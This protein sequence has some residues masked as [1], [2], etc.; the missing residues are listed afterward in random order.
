[1]LELNCQTGWKPLANWFGVFTV[2][3][4]F[5]G[6]SAGHFLTDGV[7]L[8]LLSLLLFP[9]FWGVGVLAPHSH[10]LDST[11]LVNY[12]SVRPPPPPSSPFSGLPLF[13]GFGRFWA[14]HE[15]S[16]IFLWNLAI[17]APDVNLVGRGC[18]GGDISSPASAS[19]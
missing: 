14:V 17:P 4:Q 7:I 10:T 13:P 5:W 19:S 12:V 18:S 9:G 8:L 2:F 15:F 6:P 1:M 11:I 3:Q 16:Q